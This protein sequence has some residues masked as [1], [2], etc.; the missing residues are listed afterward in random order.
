MTFEDANYMID[1]I[2]WF[3]GGKLITIDDIVECREVCHKALKKQIPKKPL[4]DDSVPHSRCPVC[5]N[6]VS[7]YI[8]SPKSSYCYHCGQALD[9]GN[10]E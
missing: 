10:T 1:S 6:V 9:W 2:S 5:R 3:Y 7:A 8:D 4:W